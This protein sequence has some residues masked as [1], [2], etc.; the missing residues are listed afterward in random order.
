MGSSPL[1]ITAPDQPSS[2]SSVSAAS[3]LSMP[4]HG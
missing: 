1:Q 4:R 3:G 2:G